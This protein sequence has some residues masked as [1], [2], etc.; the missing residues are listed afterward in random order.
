MAMDFW[1]AQRK[2]RYRT[3]IFITLFVI[4]TLIMATFV[5]V[6]MRSL[7][8][9]YNTIPVPW[10]GMGFAALT[11]SVAIIQYLLFKSNGGGFVAESL[12]GRQISPN[13]NDLRERQL[14]NIVQEMAVAAS[15]PVPPVYILPAHE[16]NAF[17]AGL[18]PQDA[19][20]T[21]TTGTLTLLNRDELQGVIAHE[22]GHVYNGD[23]TISMRLAALVMGF[24]FV[25][26]L[27]L[28]ILQFTSFSSRRNDNGKQGANPVMVA[29]LLFIVAG[30]CTYAFGSLLKLAISRQREYLADACA[31]QFTRNPNG[32]ANA[33]RKIENSQISDMPSHGGAYAH[34]Y[35]NDHSAFSTLFQ[36][37]PPLEKRIAAIMGTK[38]PD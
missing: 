36:T 18:T 6:G 23:M 5:E 9:N 24:F 37:H 17:A 4:L 28:R 7:V 33:L 32:I 30:A 2:A 34:L 1:E 25:L 15:L 13:T 38:V 35:F 27:G 11:F 14:L 12:G 16:I 21:V 8:E 10:M 26:Y 19:A 3:T 20:V 29:A 31:V 22:L